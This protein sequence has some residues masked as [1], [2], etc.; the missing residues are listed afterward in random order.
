MTNGVEDCP[1]VCPSIGAATRESSFPRPLRLLVLAHTN[2]SAG[3]RSV[4]VNLLRVLATKPEEVELTAV[5]PVGCDYE[6]IAGVLSPHAIW[7]DQKG[8]YMKRFLF[9]RIMLP[10]YV[11]STKPDVIV[12]LG[13][14]GMRDPGP[15]QVI[16]VQD[17]HF[18]YPSAHYGRM[19]VLQHLR[20]FV[21][22]RQ[23]R[24]CLGRVATVYGQTQTMLKRASHTF[25]TGASTKLLPKAI[26]SNVS[27][28]LDD[29]SQPPEF[30]PF[31]SCF[32]LIC[33]TRYY[34]HKNIERILQ[35]FQRFKY[36]LKDVVVFITVAP[37]QHPGARRLLRRIDQCGLSE[38][39]INI[40]P[41]EQRRIPSLFRHCHALLLPT[42]MESFSAAYLEAMALNLPVLT[43]DLDFA[44]EICGEGALYFDP[45]SPESMMK[46]IIEIRKNADLRNRL[47][48]AAQIKLADTHNQS[49]EDIGS[50]LINDLHNLV[51]HKPTVRR[52]I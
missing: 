25:R 32:R 27:S 19:T 44:R 3:A 7:F 36:K 17:P 33:L 51:C 42:L 41:V 1:D 38:R 35:L 2:R 26:S 46:A 23:V 16:L 4:A 47:I 52:D 12:S 21:Q 6:Q 5:V 28:N 14:I 37:D 20:Y 9:D 40:G 29:V 8:S 11:R 48:E 13:S 50:S 18:V 10:T 49:W 34:P 45:W 31:T 43:S 15:A 22:R 39:I 30:A 24:H